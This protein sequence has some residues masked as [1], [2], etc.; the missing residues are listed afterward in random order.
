MPEQT[1][2]AGSGEV[3]NTYV[4]PK[5]NVGLTK[6]PI[7]LVPS[8]SI[9]Y[10]P[11]AMMDGMLKY[12][13]YNWR[14]REVHASI[15]I[16]ACRRHLMAW[17]DGE[18]NAQDSGVPHLGHALACIGIIVDAKVNGN[19]IDDRPTAVDLTSLLDE[20]REIVA[21]VRAN[22]V[23]RKKQQQEES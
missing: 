13:P 10:Q 15:Y 22:N 12:G 19:L 2:E 14:D 11:L 1:Q 5:D 7:H 20:A 6:A 9:V 16:A 17:L 4:N 3:K 18:E 23:E 8:S 21:K